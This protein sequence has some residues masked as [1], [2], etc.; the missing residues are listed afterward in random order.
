MGTHHVQES[1]YFQQ[2]ASSENMKKIRFVSDVPED[3]KLETPL[4]SQTPPT[5]RI[6]SAA[7]SSSG[8]LS[9]QV[10]FILVLYISIFIYFHEISC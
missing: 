5:P 9:L 3:T 7:A 10:G 2:C 6:I 1:K 4:V 8:I